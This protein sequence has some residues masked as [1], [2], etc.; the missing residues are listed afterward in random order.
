MNPQRTKPVLKV[1]SLLTITLVLAIS[2]NTPAPTESVPQG[3]LPG[4]LSP[5]AHTAVVN[6]L[7]EPAFA[8]RPGGLCQVGG[9]IECKDFT[10]ICAQAMELSASDKANG[11]QEKWCVNESYAS[12]LD[13]NGEWAN[14]SRPVEVF[15]RNGKWDLA[16]LNFCECQ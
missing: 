4:G 2:C 3:P 6:R 13:P 8:G 10:P 9:A 5:E 12:R 15:R 7:R 11:V 1:I 16:N 14:K